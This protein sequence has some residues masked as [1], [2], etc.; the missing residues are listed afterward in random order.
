[1]YENLS[2]CVVDTG[3]MSAKSVKWNEENIDV[4]NS[5]LRDNIDQITSIVDV[6]IVNSDEMNTCVEEF[7][8]TLTRIILPHCNVYEQNSVVRNGKTK[9]NKTR[10]DKPW[11]NNLCKIRYAVL[12]PLL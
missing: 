10:T 3:R 2:E 5:L 8:N 7:C 6:D 11:F 1:M 12:Q 4:I 9:S